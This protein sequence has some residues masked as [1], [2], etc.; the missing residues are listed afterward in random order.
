MIIGCYGQG[1]TTLVQRMKGEVVDNIE[2]TDGIVV[3][4]CISGAEKT[5]PWV[6][7]KLLTNENIPEKLAL[8]ALSAPSIESS[9]SLSI[10]GNSDSTTVTHGENSD[11]KSRLIDTISKSKEKSPSD[12]TR[13]KSKMLSPLYFKTIQ[14]V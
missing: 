9:N 11:G 14:R 1:K 2:S 5:S 13:D 12:T 7:D 4:R 3:S 6:K 8:L 10:A